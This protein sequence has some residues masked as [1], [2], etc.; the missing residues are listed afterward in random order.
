MM[1]LHQCVNISNNKQASLRKQAIFIS[2]WTQ[3][4]MR[5]DTYNVDKIVF[6]HNNLE[7]VHVNYARK[8]KEC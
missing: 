6:L 3:L 5:K 1:C 8:A 7:S 2:N 4:W